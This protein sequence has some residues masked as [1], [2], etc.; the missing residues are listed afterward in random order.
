MADLGLDCMVHC[1]SVMHGSIP[2]ITV[3]SHFISIAFVALMLLS[4]I[5]TSCQDPGTRKGRG[6]RLPEGS[7][8]RGEVAF[9]ALQCN[10]C[11]TVAGTELPDPEFDSE[12]SYQLGGQVRRVKSYGELVTSIIQPQHIIA[13]QLIAKLP[14]SSEGKPVSPMPSVVDRMTVRQLTDI[15][16]FLNA[17]YQKMPPSGIT[18][19]RYLP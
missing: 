9:V 7:I 12:I 3:M 17:S 2:V 18:F 6:F 13:P 19:P 4:L 1:G 5:A 11:H 8:E 16:A 10:R 15:V 14:R